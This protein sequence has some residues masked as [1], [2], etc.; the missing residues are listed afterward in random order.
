MKYYRTLKSSEIANLNSPDSELR[1]LQQEKL[2]LEENSFLAMKEETEKR[3]RDSEFAKQRNTMSQL[4]KQMPHLKKDIASGKLTF[5]DLYEG[6]VDTVQRLKGLVDSDELAKRPMQV[7]S[8]QE[9]VL[10]QE[11]RT[12]RSRFK[13]P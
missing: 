6:Y 12:N 10:D 3:L 11:R 7:R 5:F 1:R 9:I 2:D 8:Y 4:A 13:K